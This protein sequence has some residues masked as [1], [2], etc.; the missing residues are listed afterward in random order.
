M[1][2]QI[3]PLTAPT[4][5][6]RMRQERR[7]RNWTQEDLGR[8]LH[9]TKQRIANVESGREMPSTAWRIR[10]ANALGL[11]PA[12]L[13]PESGPIMEHGQPLARITMVVDGRG[14]WVPASSHDV[15]L[16][17]VLTCGRNL[18]VDQLVRAAIE[19]KVAIIFRGDLTP[20][21]SPQEPA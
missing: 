15:A 17:H 21:G 2:P 9:V 7:A 14:R 20:N 1:P 12:E 6:A 18:A 8:L 11:D 19:H 4:P 10:A 3:D 5:G 13:V 16:H